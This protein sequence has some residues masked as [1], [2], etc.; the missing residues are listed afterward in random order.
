MELT[1][2]MRK[3]ALQLEAKAEAVLSP[4]YKMQETEETFGSRIAPHPIQREV[5]RAIHEG[6]KT[7][8]AIFLTGEMGSGKTLIGI[9]TSTKTGSKRTLIVCPPHL[10]GQWKDEILRAYPGK[11]IALVPDQDLKRKFS[12]SNMQTL[13]AIH[14]DGNVDYVIISREAIKTDLPRETANYQDKKGTAKC[15][16]CFTELDYSTLIKQHKAKTYCAECRSALYQ[17]HRKDSRAKPSLAKYIQKKMK[18]FF[19]L[20][21]FDEVHELKA[22]DSA[23]GAV[24]GKLGGGRAK[25]LPMTGT[26][27]GGKASDIFY[28]LYRT[29]SAQM[30]Q[31]DIGYNQVAKFVSKY[32]I[33]EKTVKI[34]DEDN[35]FSIGKK[36]N[37]EEPRERPGLSPLVVGKFLIDKTAFVRLS[38][39]AEELPIYTEHP[40][41]CEVHPKTKEGYDMLMGYR[42]FLKDAKKPQKIISSAIQAMLR[43]TDTH[44]EE[45]ISNEVEGEVVPLIITPAADIPFGETDKEKE[46]LRIIEE[47]KHLGKKVLIFTTQTKKRDLQPRLAK[48]LE[49]QSIKAAVMYN[50]VSTSKRDEW[51]KKKTSKIDALICH[52]KLVSTGMNLL[53]YPDIVFFDTG[54]STYTLRQASRRSYRINQ[55]RS[56]INV[57][58]FYTVNTIQTDCL[59]LMAVKNEVSLMAEGEIQEGGL[60]LMANGTS[61]IMSQLA[62]VINGDLKTENPI[63]VFSRLNKLNNEGKKRQS[64]QSRDIEEEITPVEDDLPIETVDLPPRV[65]V[66]P[67]PVEGNTQLSLW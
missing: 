27:M 46:L 20:I 33:S 28:L 19:D 66:P 59:S 62:K 24:L 23:Q 8:K 22:G 30:I 38:D 4:L 39:F 3:F 64:K 45:V 5:V 2:F 37:K 61:S 53:E 12:V 6:F 58:Y 63:E 26:L 9:L 11:T 34:E 10:L 49:M 40:V 52:P 31:E 15:P 1:E 29:A 14:A 42:D 21:I 57:Y 65:Y 36:R 67:V 25:I 48:L 13:Q 54:Y 51:I 60:S 17:Y 56:E 35:K 7:K 41:A 55:P 16:D 50:T 47:A 18:G 43:Y 44:M 32:G